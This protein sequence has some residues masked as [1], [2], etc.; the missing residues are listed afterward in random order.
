MCVVSCREDVEMVG[1]EGPD[2][3]TGGELVLRVPEG[4]AETGEA[5]RRG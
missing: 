4:S 2:G 1:F 5:G 3:R